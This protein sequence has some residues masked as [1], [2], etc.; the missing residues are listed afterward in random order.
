MK[1]GLLILAV[2]CLFLVAAPAVMAQDEGGLGMTGTWSVGV[3]AGFSEKDT[4]PFVISFKYWDP[5]WELGTEMHTSFEEESADY[6]QLIQAWLAYRY[7]L[8][9]GDDED[10]AASVAFVGI[11]V[12]GLFQIFDDNFANSYGP[13]A[14]VGWDSAEWGIELKGGWYDPMLY[15]AVVYYHFNQ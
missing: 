10:P 14:L 2:V 9:M 15:S 7:D 12:G 1:K 5:S 13:I 8:N 11:G 3:G 4:A 6:D